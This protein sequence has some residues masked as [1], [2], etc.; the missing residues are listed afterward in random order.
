MIVIAFSRALKVFQNVFFVKVTF[1]K[2]IYTVNFEGF[3]DSLMIDNAI[4]G[5]ISFDYFRKNDRIDLEKF[6]DKKIY[7]EQK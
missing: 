3:T 2:P 6:D 4:N 1:N 7:N 5:M